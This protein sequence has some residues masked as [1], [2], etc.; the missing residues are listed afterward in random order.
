MLEKHILDL[1]AMRVL[2]IDEVTGE[3]F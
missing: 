2:V 3:S 1:G